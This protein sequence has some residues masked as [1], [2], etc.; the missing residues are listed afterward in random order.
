MLRPSGPS[1]RPPH[2]KLQPSVEADA[3]A[4]ASITET[5]RSTK[6]GSRSVCV[7]LA[8][9]QRGATTEPSQQPPPQSPG[10]QDLRTPR[11][12]G[13]RPTWSPVTTRDVGPCHN[14]SYSASVVLTWM[15]TPALVLSHQIILP[16]PT[17]M[18]LCAP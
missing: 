16:L 4:R 3:A 11:P 10:P 13:P 8:A 18:L 7:V 1:L 14:A 9:R 6:T 12:Q 5:R 17:A 2:Q 15:G